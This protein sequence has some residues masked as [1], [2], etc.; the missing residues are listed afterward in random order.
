MDMVHGIG[1]VDVQAYH[2]IASGAETGNRQTLYRAV[3]SG[4]LESFKVHYRYRETIY[5][6]TIMR[7]DNIHRETQITVDGVD[8]HVEAIPLVDDRKEH[9]VEVR[10]G[11]CGSPPT[12]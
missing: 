2:R 3:H 4:R 11:Q 8:L 1:R 12:R 9:M 5:H 10:T 7:T 6:I